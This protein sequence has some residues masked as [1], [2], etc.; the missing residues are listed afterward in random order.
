MSKTSASEL[1]TQFGVTRARSSEAIMKA[2]LISAI[3]A[4]AKTFGLTH[5][6]IALRAQM[7]RT[8]ITGILSGSLQ[9]VTLDRVL[10]IADAV[11]L[12]T[13]IRIKKAA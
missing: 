9:K 4:S 3:L 8:A 2:K 12:V 6:D 10:K 5:A 7:P 1:A 13:E 11:N